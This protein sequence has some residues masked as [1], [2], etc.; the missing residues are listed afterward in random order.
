MSNER[1]ESG[2]R[3]SPFV[4]PY[5]GENREV[6]VCSGHGRTGRARLLWLCNFPVVPPPARER[7][8]SALLP[9]A[10]T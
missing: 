10:S 3:R 6:G 2:A 4:P 8:A 5:V 9:L 1:G 7:Q